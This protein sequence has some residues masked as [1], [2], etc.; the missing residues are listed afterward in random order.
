M[1]LD[2]S[3]LFLLSIPVDAPAKALVCGRSLAGVA[4]SDPAGGM[5]FYLL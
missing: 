1:I 2:F 4:G 5:D 3:C